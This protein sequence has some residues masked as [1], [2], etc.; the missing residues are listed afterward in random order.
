VFRLEQIEIGERL[1]AVLDESTASC[2]SLSDFLELI[3]QEDLPRWLAVVRRR[4]TDLLEQPEKELVRVARIDRALIDVLTF[5]DPKR[6]W[7]PQVASDAIDVTSIVEKWRAAGLVTA[8]QAD[9]LLT[10]ATD[11]GL[12]AL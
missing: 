5:L 7:R 4:V 2:M 1:I 8:K 10:K 6:R 3:E 11:S 9:G 12:A